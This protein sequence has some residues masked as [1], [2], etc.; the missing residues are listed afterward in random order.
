MWQKKLNRFF[1]NYWPFLL[2]AFFWILLTL[3]SFFG[4]HVLNNLEPYPDSL[5]YLG[6]ARQFVFT[7]QFMQPPLYPQSTQSF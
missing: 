4:T 1:I 6:R 3:P 5:Y 7:G 2:S